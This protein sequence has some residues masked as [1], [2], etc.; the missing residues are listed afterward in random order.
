M[1][2]SRILRRVCQPL[3]VHGARD[4]TSLPGTEDP[5]V[6]F[7]SPEQLIPVDLDSCPAMLH[8]YPLGTTA[9]HDAL[10][11]HSDSETPTKA[12]LVPTCHQRLLAPAKG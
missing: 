4:L 2:R 9:S 12:I 7:V 3:Q 10:C 11:S 6:H 5:P 1:D 8:I